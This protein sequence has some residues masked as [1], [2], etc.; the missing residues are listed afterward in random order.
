MPTGPIELVWERGGMA[1]PGKADIVINTLG[2]C[3]IRVGDVVQRGVPLNFYKIAVFIL[4]SGQRYIASRDTL[5]QLLWAEVEDRDKAAADL[6]QSL[7]RIRRLQ[8]K[9][10][11]RLIECNNSSVYLVEDPNV[12]WDL[13]EFLKHTDTPGYLGR[14][15]Y[16][17]E[18]LSDIPYSGL[19]FE[20][21]LSEQRQALRGEAIEYL[22]RAIADE[23]G[24]DKE[25]RYNHA[26]DLLRIDPCHEEAYRLLMIKAASNRDFSQLEYLYS[27]CE[28][29]LERD[30]GIQVS[31]ETR[32]LHSGLKRAMASHRRF[33]A[34]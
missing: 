26:R 5:R 32:S 31:I 19:D 33:E 7:M 14:I 2:A 18:L 1:I 3:N 13:R 22:S 15:S 4:L 20:D 23:V 21:W 16:P 29:H 28:R 6:R 25:D 30:L 11:F 27:R 10:G 12:Y 34:G 8:E 9:L 24:T 17:G